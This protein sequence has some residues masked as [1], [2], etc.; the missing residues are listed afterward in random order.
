MGAFHDIRPP[1]GLRKSILSLSV[2][3]DAGNPLERYYRDSEMPILFL[4]TFSL[5][6]LM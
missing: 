5:I 6:R 4:R 1:F 2:L 3:P